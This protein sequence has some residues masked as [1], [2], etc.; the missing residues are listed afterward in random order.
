LKSEQGDR[1]GKP[2][3]SELASLPLTYD[4]ART[5][6]IKT[7]VSAL[8]RAS[9]LPLIA[10]GSGGS[11]TTSVFVADCHQHLSRRLAKAITPLELIAD[12]P[13]R[14]ASYVILSAAG[15]NRD[16]LAA[17]RHILDA[18]PANI[19]I[20]CT[21]VGSPLAELARPY[22]WIDV[23]EYE[24]P[25]GKDGFV[26]T[27]SL[28]A[29]SVLV[30]RAYSEATAA[31]LTWPPAFDDLTTMLATRVGELPES[32]S[33]VL[34]REHLLVIHDHPTR[35][36]A[37]DLESKFSEAALGSVQVCDL[38]S[39]A[40]GRHHW[41]AK[42]GDS[43]GILT[44]HTTES[45]NL[46]HRTTRLL[47]PA[48]PIADV[49]V[50]GDR[51][52]G[53][54]RAIVNVLY[55]VGAAGRIRG[56]DPGRP[57]VPSY[58]SRIYNLPAF[59]ARKRETVDGVS[60]SERYAIER[61]ARLG[62]A[63][64][65]KLGLLAYWQD[66]YR[67]FCDAM[68]AATFRAV[69]FDYDGTLCDPVNRFDG[70]GIEVATTLNELL[71]RGILIGIA[72]G[73]GGSVREDLCVQIPEPTLQGKVFIGYHNGAEL[74]IL[75]DSSQP[76]ESTELDVPLRPVWDLLANDPRTHDFATLKPSA[77]QIT[78]RPN[79][80]VENMIGPI[81]RH[82]AAIC[83]V[84]VVKSGHSLDVLSPAVG[85]RHLVKAIL[86]QL[87]GSSPSEVLIIGDQ[88]EWPG[89]DYELL[90]EPH[91]VS[92]DRVSPDPA[93]CWNLLPSGMRGSQGVIWYLSQLRLRQGSF[94]FTKMRDQR[95]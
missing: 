69:I 4:W 70:I 20:L 28:F 27:N 29:S 75:S 9:A 74:G 17:F 32:L 73:R 67:Q 84:P 21:S 51:I 53:G 11:F 71:S 25:T 31:E 62:V 3:D 52:I 33:A 34:K 58:G 16:I 22:S 2:Y 72:T 12:I 66:A 43:T 48:I 63:E 79:P 90:G 86:E 45:S 64:L 49:S 6:E 24:L 42:R 44:L 77:G 19:I 57:G 15:K 91:S 38:R 18:E 82:Y 94:T 5:A 56:I 13:E 41:L 1:V 54:I 89:N 50:E 26:A 80:G 8:R 7:L 81:V 61:K 37:L 59:S 87:P 46:I 55:V 88:G 93:T 83:R 95:S 47:P 39:F 14:D 78:I 76:P 92:V 30:A 35:A 10:I 65:L 40:H 85:K 23:I 68:C 36:A 60:R